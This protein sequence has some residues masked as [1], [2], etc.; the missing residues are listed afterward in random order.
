MKVD[1]KVDKQTADKA[2]RRTDTQ[3]GMQIVRQVDRN[4]PPDRGVSKIKKDG[5]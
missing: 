4:H 3:V 5:G 2:D 1:A